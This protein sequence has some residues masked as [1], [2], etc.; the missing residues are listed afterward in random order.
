MRRAAQ[1]AATVAIMM[2]CALSAPAQ[3]ADRELGDLY[4]RHAERLQLQAQFSESARLVEIGLQYDAYNADLLTLRAELALRAPQGTHQAIRSLERALLEGRFHRRTRDE[5]VGALAAVLV[6]I[7]DYGDAL[8]WISEHGRDLQSPELLYQQARAHLGLGETQ[9]AD[10]RIAAGLRRYPEDARFVRLAVEQD[11]LPAFSVARWLDE[12]RSPE[13]DREY[14]RVLRFYAVSLHP[15]DKQ[16]RRLEQYFAYGGHSPAAVAEYL[17]YADHAEEEIRRFREFGGF[18]T[19]EHI[20]AFYTM[21]PEGAARD[22]MSLEL[23]SFS[24]TVYGERDEYG[25]PRE[26]LSYRL[27]ELVRYQRDRNRDGVYEYDVRLQDGLP[28]I[29]RLTADSVT[30]TVMYRVYPEVATVE[31]REP[32]TSEFRYVIV[33]GRFRFPVARFGAEWFGEKPQI[34][35]DFRL[36]EALKLPSSSVLSGH[37]AR[38][39]ERVPDAE[40]AHEIKYL[41]SGEIYR[42]TA[43][44]SGDGRIDLIVEY[45]DNEP[46]FGLRDVTGDGYFELFKRYRDGV[47]VEVAVD[48]NRD[49]TY[50]YFEELGPPVRISWDLVQ[51]GRVDIREA[52]RNDELVGREY[53]VAP[54]V[55]PEVRDISPWSVHGTSE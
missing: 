28:D 13:N 7:G 19:K 18:N 27:G 6:R 53:Q 2:M 22:A 11:P 34:V 35:S 23:W 33:P 36:D 1:I 25:Y 12:Y 32:D 20:A 52:Y 40:R 21:L 48:E 30:K 54:I 5:A 8:Q 44:G 46:L 24:G 29:Y 42:V 49:G 50:T 39:E 38:I 15:G 41:D 45:R 26:R 4:F 31:R 51:D 10:A 17:R 3:S 16:Q 9:A 37:A 55:L 14:L 47:L 43:D